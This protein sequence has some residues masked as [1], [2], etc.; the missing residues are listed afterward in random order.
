[1][2][3]VVAD[4]VHLP[5]TQ[6]DPTEFTSVHLRPSQEDTRM[7][8]PEVVDR[9]R[10]LS[11]QGHGSKRIARELKI[12]R[13]TV[14]RYLGGAAAG[15]QQRPAARRLGEDTLREVHRLYG[16]W[17]RGTPSSSS[18]RSFDT[19]AV[20]ILALHVIHGGAK[21]CPAAAKAALRRPSGVAVPRS[22]IHIRS[23]DP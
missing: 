13:N 2:D 5:E 17:P 16:S 1:M 15:F 11:G 3:R 19:L 20:V 8:K 7:L 6:A 4:L 22:D 23:V 12:S 18:R 9:I 10:E 21:I 14:R